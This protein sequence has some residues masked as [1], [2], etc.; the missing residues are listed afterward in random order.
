[1]NISINSTLVLI[2]LNPQLQTLMLFILK[3]IGNSAL[4]GAIQAHAEEARYPLTEDVTSATLFIG[5]TSDSFPVDAPPES[6][7]ILKDPAKVDTVPSEA[8]LFSFYTLT[9][10]EGTETLFQFLKSRLD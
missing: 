8:H 1:M 5:V 7:I 10:L 3:G 4:R 9:R 2:I 6:K